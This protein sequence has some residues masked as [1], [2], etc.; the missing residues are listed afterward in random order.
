MNNLLVSPKKSL[1]VIILS[2]VTLTLGF[3]VEFSVADVNDSVSEQISQELLSYVPADMSLIMSIDVYNS[4][5]LPFIANAIE[6]IESEEFQKFQSRLSDSDLELK[7]VVRKFVF[8]MQ[9]TAITVPGNTQNN[10]MGIVVRT[11][12]AE[13]VLR[14][15]LEAEAKEGGV[16]YT[17]QSIAE[18]DVYILSESE[19]DA[20]SGPA[21]RSRGAEK[22][23]AAVVYLSSDT[24][25]IS[26]S[27]VIQNL[28][29][30]I[31]SGYTLA[32]TPLKR[33]EKVDMDA[34]LWAVYEVSQGG[35]QNLP[36]EDI[37]GAALSLKNHDEEKPKFLLQLFIES[38][39]AESS[40]ALFMQSRMIKGLLPMF[41]E[42]NPQLGAQIAEAITI[43]QSDRK[44]V[45]FSW[46]HDIS[47]VEELQSFIEELNMQ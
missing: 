16:D 15:M 45:L 47:V 32:H 9:D 40:Q 41:F 37:E 24:V 25:L 42:G 11:D 13:D 27:N 19:R 12:M 35:V 23:D 30:K 38:T 20:G 34:Y 46:Q 39:T 3:G 44:E 1:N 2:I 5:H 22:N 36:M 10:L 4:Y 18:R 43:E 29:D 8:F 28:M 14:D 31:D 21:V 17:T 7:N 6:E 26:Q 33:L